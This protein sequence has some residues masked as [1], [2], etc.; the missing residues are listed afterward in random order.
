MGPFWAMAPPFTLLA[1]S[2]RPTVG[3]LACIY[4]ADRLVDFHRFAVFLLC[5]ACGG[6]LGCIYLAKRFVISEWSAIL[7]FARRSAMGFGMYYLVNRFAN[8]QWIAFLSSACRSALVFW[9]V[10]VSQIVFQFSVGC[11]LFSARLGALGL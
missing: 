11:V 6:V 8:F 7:F 2:F 3:I 9:D 1:S 5:V 4:F 10:I